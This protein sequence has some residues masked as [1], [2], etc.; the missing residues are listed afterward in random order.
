MLP[1]TTE[2]F[3][4]SLI[5]ICDFD[6]DGQCWSHTLWST[7]PINFCDVWKIYISKNNKCDDIKKKC[8]VVTG[9]SLGWRVNARWHP[10]VAHLLNLVITT[11]DNYYKFCNV[12][13]FRVQV[14]ISCLLW[15]SVSSATKVHYFV[16]SITF[17][18]QN[19]SRHNFTHQLSLL[20]CFHR[21]NCLIPASTEHPRCRGC[22]VMPNDAEGCRGMPKDTEVQKCILYK[23]KK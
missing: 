18:H 13:C 21:Q 2:V 10:K 3:W 14:R 7:L 11:L 12:S 22:W 19:T 5:Q 17:Q 8:S 4:K 20:L 23:L 15:W 6:I 16:H 9:R 1:V